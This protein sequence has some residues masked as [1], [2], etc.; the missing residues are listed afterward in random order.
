[1][2]INIRK[3]EG[4]YYI[5]LSGRG[6]GNEHWITK[7]EEEVVRIVRKEFLGELSA[8]DTRVL[9]EMIRNEAKSGGL[10]NDKTKR[11]SE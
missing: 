10:K 5:K 4:G 11:E 6:K 9:D 7:D 3:A 2:N 8:D 1:M